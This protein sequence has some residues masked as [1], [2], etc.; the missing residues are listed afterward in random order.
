[1]RAR[2]L[3]I[4]SEIRPHRNGETVLRGEEGAA[5]GLPA[6]EGALLLANQAAQM[7]FSGVKQDTGFADLARA[8]HV[9]DRGNFSVAHPDAALLDKTASSALGHGQSRFGQQVDKF[10]TGLQAFG[11]QGY[12][13]K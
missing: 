13:G 12:G 11:R 1:M 3:R 4:T 6:G 10:Q 2:M 5:R 8:E 9:I 7:F